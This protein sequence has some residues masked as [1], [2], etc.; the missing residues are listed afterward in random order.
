MTQSNLTLEQFEDR[1]GLPI[2][3]LVAFDQSTQTYM[4]F[5][6]RDLPLTGVVAIVKWLNDRLTTP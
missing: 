6:V 1:N 4:S 2:V 5:R 3:L